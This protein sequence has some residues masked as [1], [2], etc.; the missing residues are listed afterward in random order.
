MGVPKISFKK[1]PL[2][3]FFL[4]PYPLY[5]CNFFARIRPLSLHNFIHPKPLIPV[6]IITGI[7][8]LSVYFFISQSVCPE[9]FL[10]ND[11]SMLFNHN[12]N[13]YSHNP[14]ASCAPDVLSN[15]NKKSLCFIKEISVSFRS[16][17]LPIR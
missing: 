10:C 13:R 12:R 16:D 1:W 17:L 14:V 9:L 7:E 15:H 6:K 3:E 4:Q 11:Y 5:L 2:N 8:P